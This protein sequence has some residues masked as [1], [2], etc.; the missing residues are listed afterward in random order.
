[1]V[2]FN[3]GESENLVF[4]FVDGKFHGF[5]KLFFSMDNDMYDKKSPSFA[6]M[7]M[8]YSLK[9]LSGT[10]PWKTS[11]LSEV[12]AKP[13]SLASATSFMER[14]RVWEETFSMNI[15]NLPVSQQPF[16]H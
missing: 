16:L 13:S 9:K 3:D 14:E 7:K 6:C 1:M 5:C 10:D 12:K 4:K 15:G 8:L 2:D 11:A